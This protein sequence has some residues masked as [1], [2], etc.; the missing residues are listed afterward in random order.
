VTTSLLAAADALSDQDLLTQLDE[1]AGRERETVVELVAHL[2]ALDARPSL[3]AAKGYG[4]LFAYCREALRLSEDAAC[5]RIEVARACR[6]LPHILGGLASGAL[7]LTAVRLLASH[8]TPENCRDVL[9]RAAG[10]RR[11]EID[12]LVAELAPKPDAPTLIRRLPVPAASPAADRGAATTAAPVVVAP[13]VSVS[14]LST[15]S[16]IQ[17]TAPERFRVQLTVGQATH[18]KL[19]R[20]QDLLRREIPTG[21]PAAIVDQA[22]TLLL[23]KVETARFGAAA[24]PRPAIRSRTDSPVTRPS[25]YVPRAVVREIDRRDGRQCAFRSPDGHRCSEHVF[26]EKH[27]VIPYAEGGLATVDNMSLRCFRHNQYE[28]ERVFG[29]RIPPDPLGP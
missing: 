2:A 13:A 19:R 20:L 7:S 24:R 1:L 18:D 12:V 28:A 17:P 15:R 25:R 26:L 4:S 22:L 8:L 29:P 9:A 11:R 5:T 3:Y 6:K 23:E 10:M 21:D 27:H 14:A 16:A